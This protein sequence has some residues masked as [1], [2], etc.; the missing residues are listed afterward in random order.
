[1]HCRYRR[2]VVLAAR[3]RE[4]EPRPLASAS[5][6]ESLSCGL[7]HGLEWFT[8]QF[9][10]LLLLSFCSAIFLRDV[11]SALRI[12]YRNLWCNYTA[13]NPSLL[14]CVEEKNSWKHIRMKVQKNV[15]KVSRMNYDK[16]CWRDILKIVFSEIKMWGV[17]WISVL[18]VFPEKKK[19]LFIIK[20]QTS[21]LRW[22]R[23]LEVSNERLQYLPFF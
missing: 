18:M 8:T 6:T 13:Y 17:K 10:R 19:C 5:V 1:M 4:T 15:L 3:H 20:N 22:E 21:W 12:Y 9:F 16:I 23:I 7:C 2:Q 11:L 14:G